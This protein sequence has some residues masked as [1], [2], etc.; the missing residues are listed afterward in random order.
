[1]AET[2]TATADATKQAAT[3]TQNASETK[4]DSAA[5]KDAAAQA[6]AQTATAKT[7]GTT[8]QAADGKADGAKTDQT[9]YTLTLPKDS[10]LEA[11]VIERATAHAKALGLSQDSAQKNLEH[12][13]AE[14]AAYVATAKTTFAATTKG[15][16]DAVKADP[17]LGGDHFEATVKAAAL[18]IE[19]FATP[20]FK[21]ALSDTGFGNHPE[22]VRTFARIG[23]AMS[24]DKIVKPGPDGG[25]G[26]RSYE[27]IFYGKKEE[28]T[29]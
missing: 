24:D 12:V 29:T 10:V 8:A 13:N 27:D 15:W 4:T 22:L 28:G 5:D 21:K 6:V 18:P 26:G 19:K 17:E 3:D 23:K 20:A 7:D 11:S 9:P 2:A 14:V 25:T 1:M 16:V